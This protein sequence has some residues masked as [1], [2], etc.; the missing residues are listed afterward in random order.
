[1]ID[2]KQLVSTKTETLECKKPSSLAVDSWHFGFMAIG[3]YVGSGVILVG[4][5]RNKIGN[6]VK[7]NT[8]DP[9]QHSFIVA[10]GCK[11]WNSEV[12]RICANTIFRY[13]YLHVPWNTML[14]IMESHIACCRM[15]LQQT[16][17]GA[18]RQSVCMAHN[19]VC[20]EV[21]HVNVKWLWHVKPRWHK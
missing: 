7:P 8:F 5:L 1:M 18:W 10:N 11:I 20:A 6:F 3:I 2:P 12:I 9:K 4:S 21:M 15:L 19:S 13:M 17:T 16:P 14:P